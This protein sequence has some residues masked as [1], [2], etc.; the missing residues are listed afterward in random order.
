MV[1]VASKRKG[2][3]N[4]RDLSEVKFAA[5]RS[6]DETYKAQEPPMPKL[7]M[8]RVYIQS[9]EAAGV[10]RVGVFLDVLASLS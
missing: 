3:K 5:S 7:Q 8:H 1:K 4:V 2:N 6:W 10:A 9:Q